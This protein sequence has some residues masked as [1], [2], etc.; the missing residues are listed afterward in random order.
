MLQQKLRRYPRLYALLRDGKYALWKYPLLR[1][2]VPQPTEWEQLRHITAA[3]TPAD[4]NPPIGNGSNIL[5][6]MP[7]A[8]SVHVAQDLLVAHSLR[9]R[10][11]QVQLYTCDTRLPICNI[12]NH[13]T[14]PPMPCHFCQSY[15]RQMLSIMGF[16]AS[17]LHHLVSPSERQEIE[18]HIAQL[19]PTQ[20]ASYVDSGL[21]IGQM[22]QISVRWFLNSGNIATDPLAEQTF[23]HF[24]VSGA[25]V[26]RAA[27][28]LLAQ[29]RPD[30]IYLLNGLFFE[31]QILI[32]LAREQGI[33]FVTHEGGFH[34]DSKVFAHNGIAGYYDLAAVWP[35]YAQTPLTPAQHTQLTE[36]LQQRRTGGKDVAQ[37]YPHLVSEQAEIITQLGLDTQRPILVAFSNILWDSAVLDRHEAFA[38]LEAWLT[39]T[40]EFAANHPQ[41]QLIIRVHPAEIRLALRETRQKV[42]DF[43]TQQFPHLPPNVRLIPAESSIS[44]YTLM[45]LAQV[46]LVY[47]STVGLEMTLMGKPVIVAGQT[48]YAHKGFTHQPTS[49]ATYTQLL[50]QAAE[51]PPPTPAQLEL[52]Q[53]YAH[54]FFFRLMLP[55]PLVTA[56]TNGRL[57][58]NFETLAALR[59]GTTPLL[60][61]VCEGILHQRPFL[62]AD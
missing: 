13:H 47:T 52:A 26:G 25:L 17:H 34:A 59:P 6:F 8:W 24:L 49:P 32:H 1:R 57:R 29:K 7:R 15:T 11:A 10:G 27:Q 9:L 36:Y 56:L 14:A 2:I 60:D 31:E 54:L 37:Y 40:I 12:A 41:I 35:T 53:R 16:S 20:F 62:L 33:H 42:G 22:V 19:S 38:S 18:S 5:I 50:A 58:F 39:T 48:H 4:S 46:G 3:S 44:S 43:I 51:L 28:R 30:T 55:F 61:L 45:E 21:P 23:R